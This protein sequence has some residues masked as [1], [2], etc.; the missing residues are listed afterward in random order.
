MPFRAADIGSIRRLSCAD[1]GGIG[2][3]VIVYDIG[4]RELA[5]AA[6][7]ML[8]DRYAP[9][10]SPIVEIDVCLTGPLASGV[11]EPSS[12]RTPDESGSSKTH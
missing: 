7:H 9:E 5:L 10:A 3:E 12:A 4:D 2:E 1:T 11:L 8:L 6:A